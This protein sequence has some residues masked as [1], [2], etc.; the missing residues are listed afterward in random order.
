[1]SP[2]ALVRPFAPVLEPGDL[3]HLI[4]IVDRVL[5][6]LPNGGQEEQD[7]PLVTDEPASIE[8]LTARERAESGAILAESTHRIRLYWVA[9][10]KPAQ[11]VTFA[12]PLEG[13]TRTFEILGV[14]N[15]AERGWLL[16]LFTVERV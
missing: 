8:P 5:V 13:R 10:V 2:R 4:G 3:W 14:E 15:P 7:V 11:K 16:D 9:G 12:D 1:M 6:D